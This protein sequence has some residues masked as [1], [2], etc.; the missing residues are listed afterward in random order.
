M[1]RE[2]EALGLEAEGRRW[3]GWTIFGGQSVRVVV[4]NGMTMLD[5]AASI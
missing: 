4:E 3:G 5:P 2:A 1:V